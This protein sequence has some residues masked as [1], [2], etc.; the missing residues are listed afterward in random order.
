[1]KDNRLGGL[2]LIIGAVSGIITMAV[3]PVTGGHP[4]GA[5]EVETIAAVLIGVHVVAIAGIPFLFL[6]GLALTRRLDSPSRVAVTALAIY[7][8]SLVAVMIA[9]AISGLVG[10]GI[11]RKLV[12]QN[13][14]SEQWRIMMDYNYM[15]NQAFDRIFVVA[16][17][18]A[19]AL[20]S[21]MIVKTRALSMAIGIYGLLL[22]CA[23]VIAV[24][25]GLRMDAHSFGLV[26]FGEGSWLAIVGS[27]LL[28]AKEGNRAEKD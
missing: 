10:T 21:L 16:S 1:M 13:S 28:R 9:P 24:A 22:G 27:L 11:L 6:G 18:G 3:H 20:W 19:I 15:I 8:L 17:C 14:G 25:L 23:T 5:A 4:I 26:I 2:A 12:A 7:S